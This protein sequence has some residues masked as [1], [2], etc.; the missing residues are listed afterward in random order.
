[1]TRRRTPARTGNGFNRAAIAAL[2]ITGVAA[3]F[4]LVARGVAVMIALS[5]LPGYE[6]MR[7]SPNGQMVRVLS[8]DGSVIAS[9]GPSYGEWLS[10]DEI[11]PVMIDAMVAVEDRRFYGH[12]GVDPIGIARAAWVNFSRGGNYQGASTITQ[13]LA[14]HIFL[15][16]A[17]D[18]PPRGPGDA[19]R[20]Q[21]GRD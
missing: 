6:E 8:R 15:P 1:M 17:R 7:A 10:H 2:K 4:G 5:S 14:R 21:I 20:V 9:V 3:L 12:P 18:V 11:P 13:Q 19:A 16:N